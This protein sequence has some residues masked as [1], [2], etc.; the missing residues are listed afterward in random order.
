MRD[1]TNLGGDNEIFNSFQG[2]RIRK[3]ARKYQ[4]IDF[5]HQRQ[6]QTKL[7][8]AK[9]K[10]HKN[11]E[12]VLQQILD[13]KAKKI[14]SEAMKLQMQR[15]MQIAEENKYREEVKLRLKRNDKLKK[16]LE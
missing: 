7:I 16:Q 8:K 9:I 3:G 1:S 6:S 11:R 15:N 13:F 12:K 5:D 14:Q 10:Q 2:M 4:S